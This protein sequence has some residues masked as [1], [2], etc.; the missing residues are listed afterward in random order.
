[1]HAPYDASCRLRIVSGSLL[2]GRVVVV[3]GDAPL[4]LPVCTAAANDGALIAFVST[5]LA[6]PNQSAM[7]F[8]AEPSDA[9][10]WGRT[11]MHIEQQI[12][13]VD[14]VV[15]DA[16]AASV[17]TEVFQPDLSRRGHGGIVTV[18]VDDSVAG[19]L[20]R[21]ADTQRADPA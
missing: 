5:S 10:V 15:V 18:S 11:A 9:E 2:A 20:S 12:G 1:M 6:R 3:A 17:V 21:L 19:V 13:P 4:L 7:F 14:A 16:D 8:R